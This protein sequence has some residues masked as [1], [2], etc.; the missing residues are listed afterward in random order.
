MCDLEPRSLESIRHELH[1]HDNVPIYPSCVARKVPRS[2]WANPAEKAALL[3]E[4]DKL[5]NMPHPS[6]GGKGVYDESSVQ[7]AATVRARHRGKSTVHFGRICELL[8]E[9]GAELEVG[10]A[11]RKFKARAVFLGNQVHDQDFNYALFEDLG[12]APPTIEAARVLDA[13][14]LS[15]GYIQMM[16]DATSAYTQSFLKGAETWV[17]LPRNWWPP[18]WEGKYTNPVVRL[19]L[20]LYGHPDA[21]GY[22]EEDCEKRILECGFERVP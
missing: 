22:W 11:D 8:Y 14:S 3:Q 21:G 18:E 16:S 20:A 1:V 12:S 19:T 9:K 5:R 4:R 7:E 6:G 2:Q 13:L 17:A 10:H 15:K